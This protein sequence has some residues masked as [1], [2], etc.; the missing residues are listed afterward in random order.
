VYRR[1]PSLKVALVAGFL[2]LVTGCGSSKSST[3][4]A[5]AA[6][7]ST[8]AAS[9]AHA[10][11]ATAM[12]GS[13]QKAVAGSKTCSGKQV[14]ATINRVAKCLQVGQLCQSKAVAQYPAYGFDCIQ[15]GTRWVLRK[16]A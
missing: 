10:T 2:L 3:A 5:T 8:P 16:H 11:T 7:H 6:S 13:T 12:A 4:S 9:A 15:S 1:T 14:S